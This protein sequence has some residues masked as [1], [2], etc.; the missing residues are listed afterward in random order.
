MCTTVNGPFVCESCLSGWSLD[1]TGSCTKC[2][3]DA[4]WLRVSVNPA[5]LQL[6]LSILCIVHDRCIK[7]CIPFCSVV[8]GASYLI[9]GGFEAGDFSGWTLQGQDLTYVHVIQGTTHGGPGPHSGTYYAE[10]GTFGSVVFV[11][12]AG[13]LDTAKTYALSFWLARPFTET[14]NKFSVGIEP[15]PDVAFDVIQPASGPQLTTDPEN[16]NRQA[17]M[18]QANSFGWTRYILRFQPTNAATAVH[19][20]FRDDL[21]WW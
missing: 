11:S 2:A 18:D 19:F 9:N 5:V 6:V 8:P 12:Q 7:L 20:E 15:P 21:Y 16:A 4:C 14:P 1:Y 10:A 17:I 3:A 13:G